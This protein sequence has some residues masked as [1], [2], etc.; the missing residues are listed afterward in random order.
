MGFVVKPSEGKTVVGVAIPDGI[1]AGRVT[2]EVSVKVTS[3]KP[4]GAKGAVV[5]LCSGSQGTASPTITTA[6]F[7]GGCWSTDG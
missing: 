4:N 2:V 5:D 1:D 7:C 6:R 3:V